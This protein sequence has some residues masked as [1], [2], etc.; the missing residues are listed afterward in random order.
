MDINTTR[1]AI[2]ATTDYIRKYYSLTTTSSNAP[3]Y[4]GKEKTMSNARSNYI[5]NDTNSSLKTTPIWYSDDERDYNYPET[6]TALAKAEMA[7][8]L[9]KAET[10]TAPAKVTYKESTYG[11]VHESQLRLMPWIRKVIFN[12][13]A[14]IVFWT[15]GTKTVVKA[16]TT[17]KKKEQDKFSEEYGLAMAIAKKFYITRGEFLKAVENASRSEKGRK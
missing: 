4:F 10:A 3:G 2:N 6:A 16:K 12:P 8:A 5:A 17:G 11:L 7:T 13:P 9:A 1:D 15:D 14:T